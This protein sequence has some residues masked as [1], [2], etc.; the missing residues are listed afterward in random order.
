VLECRDGL[1]R[2][3]RLFALRGGLIFACVKGG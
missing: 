3:S 2:I 1:G